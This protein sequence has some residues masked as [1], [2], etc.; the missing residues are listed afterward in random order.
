MAATITF[1]QVAKDA[2]DL[3]EYTFSSQDL[4][5]AA[6]D[7]YIVCT[8]QGQ[9][10]DGGART[11]SSASIGGVSATI[12][13]NLVNSSGTGCGIIIAPVPTG[14]TGD[15][16]ITFSGTMGDCNIAL[17]RCLGVGSVTAT[18][19][20][21]DSATGVPSEALSDTL[22]ISAGGIAVGVSQNDISIATATWGNLTERFDEQTANTNDMSGASAEFATTQTGL[23]ISCTWNNDLVRS[24]L[25]MASYPPITTNIKTVGGL[26]YAS[27]KTVGGLAK[28]SIKTIGGLG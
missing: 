12:S 28:A 10:N 20:G 23:T 14:T 8:I 27:V 25:A 5:V 15:V 21:S 26:A 19:T 17:Y 24:V 13:V 2:T 9:S 22:N 1:L 18:D 3:S 4:G 6:S 7:R 11:I 16:V